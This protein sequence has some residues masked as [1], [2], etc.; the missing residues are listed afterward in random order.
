MLIFA[1]TCTPRSSKS[2]RIYRVV[3]YPPPRSIIMHICRGI[4]NC[5]NLRDLGIK[6]EVLILN[7]ATSFAR[8]KL[9]CDG[10]FL[11]MGRPGFLVFERMKYIKKS[12]LDR[13]QIDDPMYDITSVH[14]YNISS[15]R[16]PISHLFL[17]IPRLDIGLGVP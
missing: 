1:V 2:K 12:G 7:V 16:P 17:I 9:N 15:H 3:F 8:V 6:K 11:M 5:F 14:I 10:T 13:R 4:S